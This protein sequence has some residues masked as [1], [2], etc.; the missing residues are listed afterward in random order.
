MTQTS[1]IVNHYLLEPYLDITEAIQNGIFWL[2][3]DG[4]ICGANK[5]F[6]DDLGYSQYE[7]SSKTLFQVSPRTNF[8]H[9]QKLWQELLDEKKISLKTE[10]ITSNGKTYPLHVRGSLVQL[11]HE[12][13]CCG[14][15]ENALEQNPFNHL[16][17]LTSEITNTGSWQWDRLTNTFLFT[18]E[19]FTI[20]EIPH[21]F[22]INDQSL[23]KLLAQRLDAAMAADFSMAVE[24]SLKTGKQLEMEISLHLQQN[25]TYRQVR[26][27][28]FPIIIE[29]R[30]MKFYGTIQDISDITE[31]TE[32]MYLTQFS[33]DKALEV[34]YWIDNDGNFKYANERMCNMLGYSKEE[35]LGMN[36]QDIRPGLELDRWD[37]YCNAM[38]DGE[39]LEIE[40]I[41]KSKKGER[42]PMELSANYIHHRGKEL[43]CVFGRD[44]SDKKEKKEL[45]SFTYHTINPACDMVYWLRPDGSF[46]YVDDTFC[47]TLGYTEAEI[48]QMKL[49]DLFSEITAE[50]FQQTWEYLRSGQILN[51][52]NLSITTKDGKKIPVEIYTKLNKFKGEECCCAILRDISERKKKERALQSALDEIVVLNGQLASEN[53]ILKSDIELKYSFNNI[54]S[55]D[56]SYKKIL[57]QVEQVADTD[58]TVLILGETGTGKELLAQSIHQLSNRS[59][60]TMIKIN[61]GALPANLIE[62]EL[63]GHEKGAFTGAYKQKPGRFELAHRGTLFLDEI[64]DMPLELQTKLLRVLQ[65][66]EFER[67]GGNNTIKVDVRVVAATNRNLEEQVN[68]GKFR[69]DLYYRL[70][71]FPIHNLPLRERTKDIPLLVKYFLDKFCQKAGKNI[72]EIP[73]KMLQALQNYPFPGNVRELENLVERAVIVSTGNTLKMDLSIL[74]STK[75]TFQQQTFKSL[76]AAQKDHILEALDRTDGKISGTGGAADL[77][78]INDKTLISRMKKLDIKKENYLKSK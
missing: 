24:K 37:Y 3:K 67:V 69:K 33:V 39:V 28:G 14:I 20:L 32:N 41:F 7:L 42:H 71:V 2:D 47:N 74:K 51:S 10:A 46:I 35:L 54:I 60:Q 22:D 72:T 30:I 4:I 16:R 18:E 21:D 27:V 48:M 49:L 77:L 57:K 17:A 13:V 45:T 38:R 43:I 8:S 62:S 55:K 31:R 40:S 34:I 15:V 61:C 73:E 1:T 78:E 66:G 50:A 65:E 11:E 19:M 6:A 44:V 64:G 52:D 63:F 9:W 29:G 56:P 25:G 23:K 75:Q 68:Q 76:E 26:V 36:V 70:N 58:A 53:T 5:K 12:Y 59:T